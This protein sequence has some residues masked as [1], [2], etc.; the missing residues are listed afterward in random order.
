MSYLL[1]L[2]FGL[3]RT[4]LGVKQDTAVAD[5]KAEEKAA[6]TQAN[7]I[8]LNKEVQDARQVHNE[9]MQKSNSELDADLSK[10]V[11]NPE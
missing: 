3:F 8:K 5:G 11:R 1:N 4:W 10:Y 2:I 7:V 6:E 9:V